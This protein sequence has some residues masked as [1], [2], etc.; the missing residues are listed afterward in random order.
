MFAQKLC[1]HL[2]NYEFQMQPAADVHAQGSV[3]NLG[4]Y[5]RCCR[6]AALLGWRPSR[7]VI[8]L[9][10]LPQHKVAEGICLAGECLLAC[11]RQ[12]RLTLTSQQS[13]SVQVALQFRSAIG[14]WH[15]T[16][17]SRVRSAERTATGYYYPSGLT[18]G[19]SRMAVVMDATA[20]ASCA[21]VSGELGTRRPDTRRLTG[22]FRC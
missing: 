15:A 16:P 10:E 9:H 14:W 3:V 11:N 4:R 21:A 17:L 6:L 18:S 22:C 1:A 5:H 20:D 12:L 19:S 7:C 8:C 13:Q 2:Q